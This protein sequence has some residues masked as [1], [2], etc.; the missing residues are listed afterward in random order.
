MSVELV[1]HASESLS[2]GRSALGLDSYLTA[3][4]RL[5][6]EIT[7][8]IKASPVEYNDILAKITAHNKKSAL[9]T[10]T[11]SMECLTCLF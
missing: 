7:M 11:K 3:S 1:S 5:E 2:A 9:S 10:G 6:R 8:G 4:T